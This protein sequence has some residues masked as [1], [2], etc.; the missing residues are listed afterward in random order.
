MNKK[1]FTLLELLAVIVI[2]AVI[3]LVAVPLILNIVEQSKKKVAVS[4]ATGY[5]EAIEEISSIN[6]LK[7]KATIPDGTYTDIRELEETYGIEVK[8]ER[9][10]SGV[11]EIEKNRVKQ[12]ELIINGYKI[13]CENSKCEIEG[14][15]NEIKIK[16]EE[17]RFTPSGENSEWQVNSIEEA[18]DSLG[19]DRG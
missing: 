14:K 5:I 7:G 12:G 15:A 17:V 18:L 16:A 2:L 11:I 8:G 4:S 9:P 3:A 6:E 13:I 10:K 1:G 19:G